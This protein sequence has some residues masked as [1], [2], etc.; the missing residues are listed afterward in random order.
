MISSVD[1]LV[2][3]ISKDFPSE[4][5]TSK[6]PKKK[7]RPIN[8][9]KEVGGTSFVR[10]PNSKASIRLGA[11]D[12]VT[13]RVNQRLEVVE[14]TLSSGLTH[15]LVT[16]EY[17]EVTNIRDYLTESKEFVEWFKKEFV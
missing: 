6:P 9:I 8:Y 13:V 14:I 1:K 5:V 4:L 17:V 11:I 10:F 7:K 2:K 12:L 15:R 16:H 3:Y